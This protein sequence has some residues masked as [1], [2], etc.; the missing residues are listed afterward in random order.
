MEVDEFFLKEYS[1]ILPFSTLQWEESTQ[2]LGLHNQTLVLQNNQPSGWQARTT[3][4]ISLP[5]TCAIEKVFYNT[6]RPCNEQTILIWLAYVDQCLLPVKCLIHHTP[7]STISIG[8]NN[9]VKFQ[10]TCTAKCY[11]KDKTLCLVVVQCG[12]SGSYEWGCVSGHFR[13]MKVSPQQ[14]QPLQI[15]SPTHEIVTL[16]SLANKIDALSLQV[17][18]LS[19]LLNIIAVSQFNLV[20]TLSNLGNAQQQ[21]QPV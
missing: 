17:K 14:Q 19:D 3:C 10:F 11:A 20:A 1:N 5:N 6:Q 15:A 18:N 8:T 4:S 16:T 12:P 21:Q 13:K 2:Y 7:L 9:K